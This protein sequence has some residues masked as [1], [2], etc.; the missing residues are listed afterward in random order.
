MDSDIMDDSDFG[1]DVHDESDDFVP[2]VV[3]KHALHRHQTCV[4]SARSPLGSK[5][6]PSSSSLF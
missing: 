4:E 2:E 1:A 5:L 6:T 3:R